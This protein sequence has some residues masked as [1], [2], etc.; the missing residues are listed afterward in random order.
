M[1]TQVVA[2]VC[3]ELRF[4]AADDAL[5]RPLFEREFGEGA[6]RAN[7]AAQL[8]GRRGWRA[9]FAAAWGDRERARRRE[10]MA[11]EMRR[12]RPRCA[13]GAWAGRAAMRPR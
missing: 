5:W 12:R 11:N 13:G 2:Q 3:R 10:A 7:G 1:K 6:A 8:A 4:L 9:A